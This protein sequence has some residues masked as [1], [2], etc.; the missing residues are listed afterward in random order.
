MRR[1]RGPQDAIPHPYRDALRESCQAWRRR[2]RRARLR[3]AIL[4]IPKYATKDMGAMHA[5]LMGAACPG[6]KFQQTCP[7]LTIRI[8][9]LDLKIR[10][11]LLAPQG[12]SPCA[13]PRRLGIFT[14][15]QI[16]RATILRPLGDEREVG[17]GHILIGKGAGQMLGI[18]CPLA[19]ISRPLVSRSRRWT[20][21]RSVPSIILA[22]WLCTFDP[23][24]TARP[25]G[26][27]MASRLASS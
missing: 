16:E 25:W 27:L 20:R 14:E 21:R 17:F 11:R 3:P 9:G 24:W 23:P 18:Q 7:R 6:L 19:K 8:G 4:C 22:I 5:Q 13:P 15:R 1:V 2:L 26:L 10:H 12:G